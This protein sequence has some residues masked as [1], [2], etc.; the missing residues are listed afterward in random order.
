M[1]ILHV[2]RTYYP[3]P[4]GG[5][6]EAI[7]Q[8]ALATQRL[9]FE[10]RI[11]CLSPSP[12]PSQI[13]RPEGMVIR[14]K[15]WA[16]PASCDLGLLHA[17]QSFATQARWADIIHYH[18]PWPYADFLRF[19]VQPQKPTVMTYHSDVV[20]KGMLGTLYSSLMRKMLGSM[21]AVVAT[22]P[23]YIESSPVLKA[24]VAPQRL[25]VI[26]LGIGEDTYADYLEQ[27][28]E[29]DLHE[30]FNLEPGN[31]FLFV[32]VLRAYKGLD[33]LIAAAEKSPLPVVIAGDGNLK[34]HITRLSSHNR[35]V[36]LLG[37]VTDAAKM[38]LIRDCRALILP[39]HLR[40]EAF[41]MVLVEAAMCG[42]PLI[43]CEIGTGTSFVNAHEQTGIVV[44]P[45]SPGDL[46]NAIN[47][48]AGDDALAESMGAAARKRYLQRFSGEAQGKAYHELYN[49]ITRT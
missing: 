10:N 13:T 30:R 33:Y 22:S 8:I 25:H 28:D 15:S 11:F 32:G 31:Y 20:G 27:A 47:R 18:F 38:A 44:P 34:E 35:N 17:M 40:S 1:R 23:A 36:H 19:T 49:E 7:R 41:G 39:S 46:A 16:A 9:G 2:Y 48:L 45:R 6:Q 14:S 5:L 29:I 26:P 24:S 3:D 12:V 21:N 37:Q 4:P 42:R 43:S